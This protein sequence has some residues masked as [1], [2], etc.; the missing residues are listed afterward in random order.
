MYRAAFRSGPWFFLMSIAGAMVFLMLSACGCQRENPRA[1]VEPDAHAGHNHGPG[2]HGGDSAARTGALPLDAWCAEHSVPE[3]KCTRCNPGLIA[4][5]KAANDWCAGHGLP[6]SQCILC[7]PE[8]EAKLAALRPAE[9]KVSEASDGGLPLDAWCAEHGVPEAECTRCNPGLIA[10]FKTANDWC[11]GHGLPESQ[12]ILCNPEVEAKL[13]AL[14]P[15]VLR[16]Q[17]SP[18]PQAHTT[19]RGPNDPG[20]MVE[21]KQIRFVDATILDKAG[22]EIVP[23]RRRALTVT[24]EAPAE[25]RYDQTR[26]AR[27]TP[28]AEGVVTEVDVQ[29][30]DDV[31]VGDLL[32]VVDSPAL[33]EAKSAYIAAHE[34]L[35]IARSDLERHHAIHE[36]VESMLGACAEDATSE[37]LRR[38]YADARVGDYKSRLLK[39]H[40]Q[41]EL[42]RQRFQREQSLSERGISS[43]EALQTA[44]RDLAEAEAEFAA[45]HEAI[46]IELEAE[47]LG[48]ERAVRVAEVERDSAERRLRILGLNDAAVAALDEGADAWLSRYELRSPIAGQVVV[49]TAV[50]GESVTPADNLFAI[51]DLSTMWL[52]LNLD[53]RDA[54]G[55]VRGDAVRFTADSIP[56]REFEGAID[57]VS[58]AVDDRTRTVEGRVVLDNDDGALRANMFGLAQVTVRQDAGALVV[59][60]AAV[61]SDGCCQV[62]FVQE[63]DTI[64]HPK[65]VELGATTDGVIEIRSGLSAGAP[66]VAAGS[67]LLK[68]EILKANIGAG[69]CEVEPGR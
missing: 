35:L 55:L 3:A 41:L 52:K 8:V 17:P 57:W 67:F 66:V 34:N 39:A 26:L 65:K 25:V 13:A 40:A 61:Q 30:G 14:R 68:T 24:V 4:K 59:P 54:T 64:F 28:R 19:L 45:T 9:L 56:Y 47:H 49:R 16:V 51:A 23:A 60:E 44:Q 62:V 58:S 33:G 2:E 18:S 7:N 31:G 29:L 36:A 50:V 22:L 6:E 42:A 11:A 1:A 27:I 20:C 12:C 48:L 15:E 10:K 38:K 46:D 69:C 43:Q 5:I 53:E 32:A 21:N 63:S 37:Q